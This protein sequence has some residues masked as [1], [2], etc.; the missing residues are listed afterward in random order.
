MKSDLPRQI[1]GRGSQL[2]E[3]AYRDRRQ[4]DEAGCG[5]ERRSPG[6]LRRA[7]DELNRDL[8][9]AG[10][11][12]NGQ[13]SAAMAA[14]RAGLTSPKTWLAFELHGLQGHTAQE[15]ADQLGIPKGD[16]YTHTSRVRK[17]LQEELSRR[18]LM[19]RVL[20]RPDTGSGN[21]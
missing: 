14:V 10:A 7:A 18:L 21:S 15:V 2:I 16:V 5:P 11:E 17:R 12:L 3:A 8:G 19:G 6:P 1:A 13:I 20:R 9:D 4:K